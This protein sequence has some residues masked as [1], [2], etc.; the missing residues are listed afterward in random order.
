[1]ANKENG[2]GL[3]RREFIK[4]GALGVGSLALA[5]LGAPK[6]S[7]HRV[8]IPAKWD[9]EAD[10]VVVGGGGT[11]IAAALSASEA[12]AS[13]ILIE[14]APY[15]GGETALAVGSVSAPLSRLQKEQGIQDTVES[16]VEDVI[17]AAGARGAKADR[18]L[19]AWLGENAGPTI[20]WLMEHG[21]EFKGPFPYPRH[22]VN[23]MHMSHPNSPAVIAK[24]EA[25][26]KRNGVKIMY[27]TSGKKL[28]ADA[29]NRVVGVLAM[30]E[31]KQ[32]EMTI[33]ARRGV[34]LAAGDFTANYE[35]RLKFTTPDRAR[36]LGAH[37]FNNGSGLLMGLELGAD[38]TQL[39]A[40]GS[41]GFRTMPPGPSCGP[42]GRQMFTPYD[43]YAAGA[44]I[45]NKLGRRFV[46][47][48]LPDSELGVATSKQ[49]DETAFIVFDQRVADIFNE[50]PFVVSSI[51]SVAP[52]SG[53]GGYGTVADFEALGG[54]KKADTVAAVA[55][56]FGI[57]H[58]ALSSTINEWNKCVG[59]RRDASFGRTVFGRGIRK[60]PFYIH[61]PVRPVVT[62]ADVSFKVDTKLRV[63]DVH[64]KVIPGL[65]AGGNMGRGDMIAGGH[66]T[67]IA[68]SYTSGRF[69][70]MN[71]AAEKPWD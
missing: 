31:A 2:T 15:L 7:A 66:G 16:Y 18:Q 46:N 24:L 11:G 34:I 43:M 68:W 25:A 51:A 56:E 64:G 12:G 14:K 42:G 6:A 55:R 22:R 58:I 62:L 69:A 37:P 53:Y 39:D 20:D 4:L 5:G 60:A 38:I 30:D 54:I 9:H 26:L 29:N 36:I 57:N 48:E 21:A 27:E 63:Y 17:A 3:D 19:V 50:W 33:K 67:H 70:G 35:M 45:V 71:A 65:Y 8:D 41:P 59:Q 13:V 47:E 1:M 32:K 10:V 23:R 44:I 52:V 49:P 40:W 28:F 61:G